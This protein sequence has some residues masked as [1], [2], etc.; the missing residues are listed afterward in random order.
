MR[1][2]G[3]G[4]LA[5]LAGLLVIY[6]LVPVIAFVVRLVGNQA[7]HTGQ[8]T[9]SPGL[10]RAV[11]VSVETASI[12][13]GVIAVLGIPLGYLLARSRSRISQIAGVLVQLPLALPPLVSG[14]LLIYIVGPYSFLGRLFDGALTDTRAGI[15]LAQI[16]VAAPFLIVA[17]RSAF[18]TVDADLDD[19]AATLGHTPLPRFARVWLPIAAPG[20]AAGLLLS[21][22]RAFGEFGATVILAYHPYSLPVFTFVQFGSTGLAAILSPVAAAL[23]AAAVVLV[24]A[25]TLPRLAGHRSPAPRLAA[26]RPPR[27]TRSDR[28]LSFDL[29]AR[30]GDFEL[31]VGYQPAGRSLALLGPSGA[32]KTLTLRM[33]AGLVTGSRSDVALGSQQ[34]SGLPAAARGIGYLPQDAALLPHQPVWR[35]VTFGVDADRGVAAFWLSRLGIGHLLDRRPAQLSGG[36]R[37]RVALVRALARKPQLLLLDEPSTGLD[38]AVRDQLRRDLRDLQAE[39]GLTTVVVTHDPEEAALLA[40]EVLLIWDG[41]LLQAGN[42][43]QVFRQPSSPVAARLL[44]IGNQAAGTIREE[45]LETGGLC[46]PLSESHPPPGT[47]VS[48]CIRAEHLVLGQNGHPAHVVDTIDFGGIYEVTLS[49]TADLTVT[50]RTAAAPPLPGAQTTVAIPSDAII[51]WP[52]ADDGAWETGPTEADR[53]MQYADPSGQ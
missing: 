37:R 26:P 30:L 46:L 29:E 23:A 9:G 50:A 18:A 12:A 32:G 42:Q 39:T 34:F 5:G 4:V 8:S 24:L 27:H 16:F 43:H 7:S 17:A 19:V 13:V 49:L 33:L 22:L 47:S 14:I 1:S 2:R 53:P 11:A 20:I 35:Q 51:M 3:T 48:W 40:D 31:D 38:I 10:A 45:S 25:A 6:L 28:S 52:T 15:V 36:Q 41:R 44:G 21:W